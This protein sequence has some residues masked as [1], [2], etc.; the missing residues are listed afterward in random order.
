MIK[1]DQILS[2]RIKCMTK[3]GIQNIKGLFL[4]RKLPCIC[5]VRPIPSPIAVLVR[6]VS[7][8]R[9][10]SYLHVRFRTGH[11]WS[12]GYEITR[13]KT[14][15]QYMTISEKKIPHLRLTFSFDCSYHLDHPSPHKPPS[16]EELHH[17]CF[18]P[19]STEGV[20]SSPWLSRRCSQMP[21]LLHISPP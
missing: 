5:C 15:K 12:W 4:E 20:N 8:C 6:R 1:Y 3:M 11:F 14:N 7:R 18:L 10:W 13:N 19:Y 16:F 2:N 9:A 17:C 21:R